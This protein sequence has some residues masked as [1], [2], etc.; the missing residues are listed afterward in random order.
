MSLKEQQVVGMSGRTSGSLKAEYGNTYSG[1]K[2]L[3]LSG[4]L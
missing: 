3:V 4:R 1:I 2:N